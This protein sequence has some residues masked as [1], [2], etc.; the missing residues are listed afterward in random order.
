M[1]PNIER[2]FR[3]ETTTVGNGFL[4]TRSLISLESSVLDNPA[5][6]NPVTGQPF[7]GK[8]DVTFFTR[9]EEWRLQPGHYQRDFTQLTRTCQGALISKRALIDNYGL[10]QSQANSFF[11]N[12]I[13]VRIGS[14]AT[15]RFVDNLSYG[16]AIRLYGDRR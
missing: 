12:R 3:N 4:T 7:G 2:L 1:T 13:T 9:V 14:S 11:N 8:I 6:V 5:L 10:S 16:W 15:A